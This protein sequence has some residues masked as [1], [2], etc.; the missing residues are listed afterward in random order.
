MTTITEDKARALPTTTK[1]GTGANVILASNVI[2]SISGSGT[3]TAPVIDADLLQRRVIARRLSD[4]LEQRQDLRSHYD[5]LYKSAT[6]D[7]ETQI[8]DLCK[9]HRELSPKPR[10][11]G[12]SDCCELNHCE[13]CNHIH[14]C[15]K[16]AKDTWRF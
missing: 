16:A 15:A 10:C 11:F 12:S 1:A 2:K 5:Q 4:L 6:A 3:D 7:L 9:R 13:E 14:A 8:T